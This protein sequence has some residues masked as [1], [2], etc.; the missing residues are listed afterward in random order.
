M[1][2]ISF[3]PSIFYS[4]HFCFYFSFLLCSVHYILFGKEDQSEDFVPRRTKKKKKKKC[5][6]TSSKNIAYYAEHTGM[7]SQVHVWMVETI[8]RSSIRTF[9][10][11][12][13]NRNHFFVH[14]FNA[15]VSN[16]TVF[17][18]IENSAFGIHLPIY[19]W[20]GIFIQITLW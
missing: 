4:S 6:Y 9:R 12:L 18:L 10:F 11:H 5:L 7:H 2:T 16:V 14:S 8:P 3:P 17:V 1:H 19:I 13:K 15:S 20:M